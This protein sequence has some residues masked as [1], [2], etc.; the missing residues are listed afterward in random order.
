MTAYRA[1]IFREPEG[2]PLYAFAVYLL[3][4]RRAH[5]AHF[6]RCCASLECFAQIVMNFTLIPRELRCRCYVLLVDIHAMLWSDASPARQGAQEAERP[7]LQHAQGVYGGGG[8]I[9]HSSRHRGSRRRRRHSQRS[10]SC[11]KRRK[12][13]QR[14]GHSRPHYPHNESAAPDVA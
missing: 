14:R 5:A 13:P 9:L 10:S 3:E 11:N 2:M 8:G 1:L 6:M 4:L 7:A 12:R